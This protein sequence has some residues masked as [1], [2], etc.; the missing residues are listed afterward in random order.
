MIPMPSEYRRLSRCYLL[1]FKFLAAYDGDPKEN[2]ENLTL[3]YQ[4]RKD[5]A[6]AAETLP[7]LGMLGLDHIT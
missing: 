7:D 5:L 4:K 1:V 3:T 6:D 2:V